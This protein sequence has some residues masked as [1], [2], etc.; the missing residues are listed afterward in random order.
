MV[1]ASVLNGWVYWCMQ[2]G[3]DKSTLDHKFHRQL[4][5]QSLEQETPDPV[6][7]LM[8][9]CLLAKPAYFMRD[10][11]SAQAYVAKGHDIVLQHNLDVSS[12]SME[13]I[14]GINQP[15]D[16]TQEMVSAVCQLIYLDKAAE[17]VI[18][19]PPALPKGFDERLLQLAV[20]RVSSTCVWPPF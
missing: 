11:V 13:S 17:L 15:D 9:Y 4:A 18:R 19:L 20:S 12:Q 2:H 5:L 1:H 16:D 8:I 10:T 14:L 6:T 7:L 3:G